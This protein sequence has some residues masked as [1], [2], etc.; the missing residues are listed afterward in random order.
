MGMD[1]AQDFGRRV[2]RLRRA[3]G[4]TIRGLASRSG[5]H[6][7][8]AGQLE[9]GARNPSL[10]VLVQIAEGLGVDPGVLVQGLRSG[11]R[12]EDASD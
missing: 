3:R 1:P 11:V 6:W 4:L 12:V 7:T 8:Y 9:R 10:A 2:R 5:V